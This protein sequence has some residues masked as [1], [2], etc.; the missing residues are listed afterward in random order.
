MAT[1]PPGRENR[2]GSPTMILNNTP[3][4]IE[5]FYDLEGHKT[6]LNWFLFETA[7]EYYDRIRTN[8]LLAPYREQHSEEQIAQFCTYYARR[9]KES[10]LKRL[11][12]KRKHIIMYQEYINDFYPH[13]PNKLNSILSDVA[14]NA[15][16]HM[17]SECKNCPQQCLNDYEARTWLFENHKDY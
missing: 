14:K 13:H 10:L 2:G 15:W 6:K 11:Q 7:L 8:Q 5:W 16:S 9:M 17:L 12:G 1:K 3:I 4:R